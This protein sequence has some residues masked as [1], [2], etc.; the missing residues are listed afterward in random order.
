MAETDFDAIVVGSG[1]AGAVAAYELAKAGKSTLV[2]ERGNFAGALKPF[3]RDPEVTQY[4]ISAL[5]A[6]FCSPNAPVWSSKEPRE[7][8]SMP[9]SVRNRFSQNRDRNR[10]LAKARPCRSILAGS[11]HTSDVR[12]AMRW[13]GKLW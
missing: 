3:A 1:C 2:V 7:V 13:S 11:R 8:R 10:A 12:I 9:M 5:V 6:S 4:F